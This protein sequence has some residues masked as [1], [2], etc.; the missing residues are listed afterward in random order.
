M[1]DLVGH[2][3]RYRKGEL[4]G[5][6]RKAGF[7]IE[8]ASYVDSAGFFATLLMKPFA[9]QDGVLNTRLVAIFDRFC[10]PVGRLLDKLIFASWLGKNVAVVARKPQAK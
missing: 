10:F 5:K 7:D 4:I 2:V 8:R 6:L 1:D 3:R 9:R